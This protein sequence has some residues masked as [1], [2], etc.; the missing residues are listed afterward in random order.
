M[1]MKHIGAH[2]VLS[3]IG[4]LLLSAP[5]LAQATASSYT[6]GYR[7]DVAG[8][9]T[10]I[11]LPDPD[12]TGSIRYGATR[13]T[14]NS[15]GNLVKA[16]KG[17]LANWQS[18]AV[19][20]ASWTGFTVREVTDLTYDNDGNPTKKVVSGDGVV[21]AVEDRSYDP[22]NQP[23]CTATRMYPA[24]WLSQTDA[25]VS[26]T[27][28]PD[29]DRITKTT[30]NA[31]GQLL[32]IQRA[33][34]TSLQEDYATYTYNTPGFLLNYRNPDS[35]T[36]A[37]GNLAKFEYGG[38][39][40]SKKTKWTF[41]SKTAPGSVNVADYE[42]Y[43]YDS[44]GNQ[45]T[46]RKRDGRIITLNYDG[47]S[48][49]ISK[50]VPDGCA[51]IQVGGCTPA[52]ATRDVYYSYDLAG[53]RTA[54][55]FDSRSGAD[56]VSSAY[57]G[58]GDLR[59]STISMAGF[60]AV[61]AL[62]Y[63]ADGNR[64]RLTHPDG[65]YFTSSFDGLNR[66]YN[67][68]WYTPATGAMWLQ[69]LWYD[70]MGRRASV[71]RGHS[72]SYY[73]YD[74]ISRLSA[75]THDHAG[76]AGD[77]T[78]NFT[79]NPASQIKTEDRS[80]DSYAWTGAVPVSRTYTVNGL[81][82]YTAAG[83]ASFA[84]DANGNL[85]SDGST[86]FVYDAEN[87]LVSASNGTTVEY[88]PMGRL[89]R[90]VNGPYNT[91]FVYDGDELV[92]EYDVN[93]A[94]LRRYH[95]G[96]QTD[97]PVL[98]DQGS[99]MNCSATS[100]LHHDQQGSVV[101]RTDCG[102]NVL[103]IN[104]YDEYGIPGAGN[105]GR[106]QYTGQMWLG[107]LGMYYYKARIYSPTLGRFLQT[108]PIGYEDQIN[109]YAYVRNDPQNMYDA[110]GQVARAIV[111]GGKWGWRLYRVGNVARASKELMREFS[112][113]WHALDTDAKTSASDKFK[114]SIDL[115]LGTNLY[116]DGWIEVDGNGK[117]HGDLPDVED[118]DQDDLTQADKALGQSIETRSRE[119]E[120]FPKGNPNG[121]DEEKRQFEKFKQHQERI[122]EEQRLLEQVRQ[123]LR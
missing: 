25:C 119:N 114:A 105:T 81:N 47:L 63:D 98:V 1:S 109:L 70:S 7:Y 50:I 11:I 116:S 44:N 94:M 23:V 99:A 72:W 2:A 6:T 53:H 61:L 22:F 64:T 62:D 66:L 71:N 42:Q 106:F 74:G 97:E 10:G 77:N 115:I 84:Y 85:T 58:F 80:N 92:A 123:R 38:S 41:P 78:R 79:Y 15:Y 13:N 4:A 52:T 67:T 103:S 56:G 93:G 89:W 16:E 21:I 113:D 54:A 88:D 101:A 43:T 32:K 39:V 111:S 108:D 17:E 57:D 9:Q 76:T 86:T 87:R 112:V 40:Y 31:I 120:R 68:N 33:Y 49:V 82:Q 90:V 3:M 83:A 91:R 19:D 110:G 24:Q 100:F 104:T 48:R 37:K 46:I 29:R 65:I 95:F 96:D 45:T 69:T 59:S 107:E 122:K 34:D 5:L 117:I 28:G 60:S 18:E 121:D 12:G 27:A 102:A 20:P 75:L 14:Y 26:Q 30:Y 51:P 35:L 55:K 8:R 73:S 36:D 118:M